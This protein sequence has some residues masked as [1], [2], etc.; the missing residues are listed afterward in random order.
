MFFQGSVLV[1]LM[2]DIFI[3]ALPEHLQFSIPFIFAAV[4]VRSDLLMTLR[5]H[6]MILTV[7]STGASHQNSFLL[8]PNLFISAAGKKMH[9]SSVV[10]LA[11]SKEVFIL[12]TACEQKSFQQFIEVLLLFLKLNIHLT[13]LSNTINQD[14]L[15]KGDSMETLKSP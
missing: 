3:N 7:L 2:F 14:L 10:D 15:S 4:C 9:N 6:K 12:E 13:S 8:T 11:I 1:T 5:S